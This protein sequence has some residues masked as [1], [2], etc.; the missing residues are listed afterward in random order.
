MDQSGDET[1]L[2]KSGIDEIPLIT[3]ARN[4]SKPG[5]KSTDSCVVLVGTT[6]TG[7]TSTLNIYTGN[8]LKVGEGAQSV[9]GTTVSVEDK[10]HVGGPKWIDNPGWSDSEGRSDNLVFKDLLRH[11]QVNH[12]YNVKAVVWCIMPTPRMDANLQAQAKFIDMFTPDDEKTAEN[13]AGQIWNNV[14]IICK[15]KIN[16]D[17][18]ADV[19]GAVMASKQ[20]SVHAEPLSIRFEFAAPEILKGTTEKLRKESLRMLTPGEIRSELEVLFS[21]LPVPVPAVFV[22]QKC[23]SCGQEGDP[24]L[25]TDTCHRNKKTGHTG[26]LTQRFSR[27]EVGAA[28]GFGAVGTV[29]LSIAAA[30]SATPLVLIGLPLILAPGL[31]LG[32][33]RFLNTASDGASACGGFKITDMRWSCC[34]APELSPGGCSELCDLCGAVWGSSAKPCV[35]IKHP[36]INMQKEM[37][38]YGVHVKKHDLVHIE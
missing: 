25:M 15:G 17:K 33:H 6:G 4:G 16:P 23:I 18:T 30:A 2:D 14:V 35:M 29:A 1:F 3:K 24:R 8:D 22:N 12:C 9:T 26:T 36:D 19:Q 27:P 21:K 31:T 13:E 34:N 20:N 28:M 37:D 38:G 5:D 7:K 11:M 10:I 32:G